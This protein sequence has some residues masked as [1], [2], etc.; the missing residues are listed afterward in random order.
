M[1]LHCLYNDMNFKTD[2][3]VFRETVNQRL[4]MWLWSN[5]WQTHDRL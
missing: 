5:D 4:D 3:S 2:F 1:C